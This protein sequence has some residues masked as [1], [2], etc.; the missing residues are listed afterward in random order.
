MKKCIAKKPSRYP[1]HAKHHIRHTRKRGMEERSER[2]PE[3]PILTNIKVVTFAFLFL[4]YANV[5][6]AANHTLD[7]SEMR[8]WICYLSEEEGTN[9]LPTEDAPALV[10]DESDVVGEDV[11]PVEDEE[12]IEWEEDEDILEGE[13]LPAEDAEDISDDEDDEAPTNNNDKKG[14]VDN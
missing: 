11:E 12:D 7:A 14:D 3:S 1:R 9:T 10:D 4:L 5:L 2:M 8:R 13:E 6:P